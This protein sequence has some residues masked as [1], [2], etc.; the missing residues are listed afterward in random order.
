MSGG[1][2]AVPSRRTGR[3]GRSLAVAAKLLVTA[4]CFWYVARQVDLDRML[5]ALVSVH[6]GWTALAVA[7]IMLEI[8]LVALRWR[9][10][11]LALAA[12]PVRATRMAIIAITAIGVFVGQVLPSVA[13]DGVRTWLLVRLGGD[14]RS[15]VTS[16][17]I[18]RGVGVALL[19][20]LGFLILLLQSDLA[21]LGGWREQVLV[22]YGALLALGLVGL[23]SL[24]WIVPVLGRWRALRWL[25]LLGASARHVLL[26]PR[27][28]AI[29]AL[30]LA[31]HALTISAVWSLGQALGLALALP[32]AAVLFTIMVAAAIVP[33]S[34]SGWG[35]REL[36]VVAL[37]GRHGV[38]PEHALLISVCFGLVLALAALPGAL[39]WLVYPIRAG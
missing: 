22:G 13:G 16:V 26:G 34:V 2:A 9:N 8:P 32:D 29:I 7:A 17:V 36:A 19:V 10:I 11:L 37:L 15:A 21:A 3:I 35:V 12:L 28:P 18:D 1:R 6:P 25:A 5:A 20:A 30:G 23:L 24:P 14:W 4:L 31:V 27:C 33:I 38:A 39:A